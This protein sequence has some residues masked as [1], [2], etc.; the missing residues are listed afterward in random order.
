MSFGPP[1]TAYGIV[2]AVDSFMVGRPVSRTHS[3]SSGVTYRAWTLMKVVWLLLP[4]EIPLML[5]D[6]PPEGVLRARFGYGTSAVSLA[7]SPR[8]YA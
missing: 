5:V 6:R 7:T 4:N 3:V 8:V 2:G 1:G